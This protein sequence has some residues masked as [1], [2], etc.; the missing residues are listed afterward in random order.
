MEE[1]LMCIFIEPRSY[2][3]TKG[4]MLLDKLESKLLLNLKYY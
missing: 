3:G 2:C 1:K 4:L